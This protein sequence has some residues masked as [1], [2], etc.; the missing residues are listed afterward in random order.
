VASQLLLKL[1]CEKRFNQRLTPVAFNGLATVAM[2]SNEHVR[3]GFV[4]KIMKYLGQGKLSY[5]F[6]TPLFLLGHEVVPSIG[7]KAT[8]WL[9]SRAAYYAKQ[10]DTS[11]EGIFA[12][13]LSLLAH[14]P[15]WLSSPSSSAGEKSNDLRTFMGYIIFYLKCVATRENISLIYHVSQRVK[16]VQDGITTTSNQQLEV[17]NDRLWSLSDLSQEVVQAYGEAMS[18]NLQAW[19]GKVAM[20]AGIFVVMPNHETAQSVAM[21]S[22]LPEDLAKDIDVLVKEALRSKKV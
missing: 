2:D 4:N 11:L 8:T 17:M 21:K 10:K 16:A 6:Y 7:E 14:H 19:P 20:P 1:C 18:W 3:S 22:F 12:R 5:R 13:L 9:K 15:D